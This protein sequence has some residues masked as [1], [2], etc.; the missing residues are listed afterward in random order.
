M[1]PQRIYFDAFTLLV[2]QRN[3][4][5]NYSATVYH[6]RPDCLSCPGSC[7]ILLWRSIPVY[8]LHNGKFVKQHPFGVD[9]A[10]LDLML[11]DAPHLDLSSGRRSINA[12]T[13][14]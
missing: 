10:I 3:S 8:L 1:Y 11:A 6:I 13:A 2:Q 5:Q 14:M 7:A 4:L 9:L 12:V